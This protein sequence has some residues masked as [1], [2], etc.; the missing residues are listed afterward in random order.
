MRILHICDSINPD[1]LGGYESYLHYLS[2]EMD[3]LGHDSF[4]VTQASKSDSPSV[5]ELATH[6][7]YHLQGNLLEARKWEFLA[8][9]ENDRETHVDE[10]FSDD[11]LEKNVKALEGQLLDIILDIKPDIIHAHST[12]IVFNRVLRSL[13]NKGKLHGIGIVATIHGLPKPL[14]LPGGIKTTD[15]DQLVSFFPFDRVLAVSDT[16]AVVLRGWLKRI[17]K[18]SAIT[19]LYIGINVDVF[20]PM[21]VP[22]EWDLAFMGRLERMKGVDVFPEVLEI[23]RTKHPYL[24]MVITGE[25]SL[26]DSLL[27]DIKRRG[28]G[29]LVTYLGVIETEKVP[30]LLN[31][32]RIFLY[33]SRKEPFGLS[34]LEGMACEVPVITADVYGPSEVV[35]HLKDGIAI[36]PGNPQILA[37]AID[38]LLTD[39]E[40]YDTICR[41]SRSTVVQNFDIKLHVPK[42]LEVYN[43]VSKTK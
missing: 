8:L 14:I 15:Y 30:E 3:A 16:V 12:Y 40:L 19:R 33:P 42:L 22:K 38:L 17:G 21:K 31:Q 24:K 2:R 10:M 1:G 37:D 23:L 6:R 25:G 13:R 32:S 27:A 29:D 41:S 28:V 20:R 26:K 43:E 35:T 11:D 34:V 4:V 36:T 18:E 39:K 9:P 5:E 7:T